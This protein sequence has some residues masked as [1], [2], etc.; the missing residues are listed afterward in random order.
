MATIAARQERA[1]IGAAI[2]GGRGYRLQMQLLMLTA[3]TL[4]FCVAAAAVLALNAFLD[5]FTFHSTDIKYIIIFALCMVLFLNSR[6]YPGVGISPVDEIRLVTRH[7]ST[8]FPAGLIGIAVLQARW[9]PKY[10]AFVLM[11]GITIMAVLLLRWSV[12]I[13]ASKLGLWGEPVAVIGRGPHVNKTIRYF[14]E[15]RRLGFVPVLAVVDQEGL[16]TIKSPVTVVPF[17]MMLTTGLRR[18]E[19]Q[20]IGAGGCPGDL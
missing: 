16:D 3:D 8:G 4:G 7:V 5:V 20:G 15:R 17:T 13:L 14:L 18:A 11:W 12:R 1:W 19:E 9:T 2:G 6:L 10:L